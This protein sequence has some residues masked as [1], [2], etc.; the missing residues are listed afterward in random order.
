MNIQF[1]KDKDLKNKIMQYMDEHGECPA[2]LHCLC[3]DILNQG[4]GPCRCGLYIKT[5]V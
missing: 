4:I 2:G 1:T 5:E 3:Q